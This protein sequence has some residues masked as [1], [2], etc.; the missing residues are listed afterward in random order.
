MTYCYSTVNYCCNR[1]HLNE[2]AEW[3]Y[4]SHLYMRYVHVFYSAFWIERNYFWNRYKIQENIV[5]Q[6][7]LN[8]S[9]FTSNLAAIS[10]RFHTNLNAQFLLKMVTFFPHLLSLLLK[11][12]LKRTR[13]LIKIHHARHTESYPGHS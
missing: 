12:L 7:F 2:T 8:H 9:F 3:S 10:G 4:I 13:I 11:S 6:P 1:E 5:N